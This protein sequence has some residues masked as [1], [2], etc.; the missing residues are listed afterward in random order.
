[1]QK[2]RSLSVKGL[3]ETKKDLMKV[4]NGS[5]ALPDGAI[6]SRKASSL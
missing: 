3:F 6:H 5:S 2:L 4:V 1:M